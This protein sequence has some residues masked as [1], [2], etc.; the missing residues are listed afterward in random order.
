MLRKEAIRFV[1]MSFIVILV[2]LFAA[3][4][5]FAQNQNLEKKTLLRKTYEIER[6]NVD[7]IQNDLREDK[8]KMALY[9]ISE[10]TNTWE[11]QDSQAKSQTSYLMTQV[12]YLE[13]LAHYQCNEKSSVLRSIR[14]GISLEQTY[15]MPLSPLRADYG[16]FKNVACALVNAVDGKLEEYPDIIKYFGSKNL[17]FSESH[18]EHF[19]VL[20]FRSN[21]LTEE[22][23]EY[24]IVLF[25][26]RNSSSN[27]FEASDLRIP[28]TKYH[29]VS[30][31]PSIGNSINIVLKKE[32]RAG[33]SDKIVIETG[34]GL[35]VTSQIRGKTRSQ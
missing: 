12:L 16:L 6:Q 26:R 31:E 18:N 20:V 29:K 22:N 9:K 7:N 15:S 28:W 1:F 34:D 35:K 4:T 24:S 30:L 10:F 23:E 33:E 19:V 8:P 14:K 5:T 25:F 11:L 13:A 32:S 3:S 2:I 21:E 27:I 17:A